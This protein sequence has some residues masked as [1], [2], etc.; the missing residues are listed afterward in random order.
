M[1]YNR[2]AKI[3]SN[4]KNQCPNIPKGETQEKT[5]EETLEN[6]KD[7]WTEAGET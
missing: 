3:K 6:I 2:K 4:L 5:L 1:N 7:R